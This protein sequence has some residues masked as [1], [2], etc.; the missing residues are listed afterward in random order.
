GGD[1]RGGRGREEAHGPQ[2]GRGEQ[3]LARQAADLRLRARPGGEHLGGGDLVH[4][5][6]H[7]EYPPPPR[8]GRKPVG[9]PGAHPS[10]RSSPALIVGLPACAIGKRSPRSGRPGTS[11]STES[12]RSRISS[13]SSR[14]SRLTSACLAQ[15]AHSRGALGWK[16]PRSAT[17]SPLASRWTT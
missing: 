12:V 5:S 8:Q 16:N 1:L 7:P 2:G 11:I 4:G 6:K 13:G 14:K 3:R 17:G 10:S 15:P 9:D